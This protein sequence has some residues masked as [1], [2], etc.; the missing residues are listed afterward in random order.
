MQQPEDVPKWLGWLC[1]CVG[2]AICAMSVGLIPIDENALHA[3]RAILFL[4]GFMFVAAGFRPLAHGKPRLSRWAPV[5]IVGC[6][7]TIGLWIGLKGEA[8]AFSGGLP[9]VSPET[10]VLVARSIFASMGAGCFVLLAAMLY[11]WR[12]LR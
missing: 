4:C 11:R 2:L 6:F 9:F 3:P 5:A 12:S 7:G 1:A 10:N 8:A